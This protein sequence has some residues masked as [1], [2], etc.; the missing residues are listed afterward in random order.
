MV[1]REVGIWRPG[2]VRDKERVLGLFRIVIHSKDAL[3]Q[4]FGAVLAKP[5]PSSHEF[6]EG[7]GGS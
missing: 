1:G 4:D 6:E 7:S 5:S 3:E 2:G